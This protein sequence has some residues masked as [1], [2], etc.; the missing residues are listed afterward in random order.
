[1]IQL[2]EY[3][4]STY[5]ES[6]YGTST[7]N[8]S[9]LVFQNIIDNYTTSYSTSERILRKSKSVS[10]DR[11]ITD[12]YHEEAYTNWWRW[13][14]GKMIYDWTL[15]DTGILNTDGELLLTITWDSKTDFKETFGTI[16]DSDSEEY[17]VGLLDNIRATANYGEDTVT[18]ALDTYISTFSETTTSSSSTGTVASISYDVTYANMDSHEVTYTGSFYVRAT[19]FSSFESS[20]SEKVYGETTSESSTLTRASTSYYINNTAYFSTSTTA[21]YSAGPRINVGGSYDYSFYTSKPTEK[22]TYWG[23]TLFPYTTTVTY[24]WVVIIDTFAYDTYSTR[25]AKLYGQDYWRDVVSQTFPQMVTTSTESDNWAEYYTETTDKA[26]DQQY[27]IGENK[28]LPAMNWGETPFIRLD[29]YTDSDTDRLVKQEE[30]YKDAGTGD[31]DYFYTDYSTSEFTTITSYNS[32]YE[33]TSNTFIAE[34]IDLDTRVKISF[35]LV[36]GICYYTHET[37]YTTSLTASRKYDDGRPS[38]PHYY[39]TITNAILIHQ[40]EYNEA[41]LSDYD[42]EQ[43]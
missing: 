13:N 5:T 35:T 39:D 10:I 12:F 18:V 20:Y 4:T 3:T 17:T 29:E 42:T 1:M 9:S 37:L 25:T 36:G 24:P 6:L 27:F 41:T 19:E 8:T 14:N 31:H 38:N 26:L 30:G 22:G 28:T 23:Q 16:S 21:T 33:L 15:S 7:Y 40:L 2:A 11:S 43:L 34:S 32:S